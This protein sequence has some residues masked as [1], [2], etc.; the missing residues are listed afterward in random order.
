VS[1]VAGGLRA[2]A[3]RHGHPQRYH[4]TMT[5][6]FCLI[7]DARRRDG[8]SWASFAARNGEL[9]EDGRAVLHRHWSPELLASDHARTRFVLPDRGGP[10]DG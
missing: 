7:I 4:E 10:C 6:G 2:L 3:G 5:V 8:E 1:R 9:V